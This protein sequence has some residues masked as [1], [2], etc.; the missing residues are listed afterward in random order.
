MA[1]TDEELIKGCKNGERKA[2]KLVFEKYKEHLMGVIKRY[3]KD[4]PTAEDVLVDA[5]LK[6]FSKIDTYS[7]AG[8]FAAWIR[9][10]AIREALMVYR[11]GKR[12]SY[13]EPEELPKEIV[14][15]TVLL[16]MEEKEIY[17]CLEKL[18]EGYRQVLNLYAIDG[19]KHRE[20]AEMLGISIHTSKSQLRM[21]RRRF[22]EII[23]KRNDHGRG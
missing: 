13:L 1:L 11:K 16:E 4:I 17:S 20:I 22:S 6:V 2:Q 10:I 3:V 21:A 23:E 5:F 15:P 7:G 14:R 18:P 9:R 12:M 8:S 19:Y